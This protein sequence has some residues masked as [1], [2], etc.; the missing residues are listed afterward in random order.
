MNFIS[1]RCSD[2]DWHTVLKD[3][4]SRIPPDFQH[5][6]IVGICDRN[7]ECWICAD[8]DWIGKQLKKDANDFNLFDPKP[9]FESALGI[10][11]ANKMET[12]IEELVQ[13]APLRNWLSNSSFEDFYGKVW[14]KSK[15]L[16]CGMENLRKG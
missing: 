5:L 2:E 3:E 9:V 12:E 7:V 11:R 8:T 6:L 14:A 4:F 13:K 15:E 10:S 1:G 16:E